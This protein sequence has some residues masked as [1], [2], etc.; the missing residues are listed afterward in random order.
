MYVKIGPYPKHVSSYE[1][2]RKLERHIGEDRADKISDFVAPLFH[3]W[4]AR[5]WNKR[6]IKVKIH[7]SDVWS[8]DSTLAFIILPALK[9][10]KDTKH[11][12]PFVDDE[13]VPDNLKS[14]FAPPI[15]KEN[16][17]VDD[18]HYA[19]WDY[20]LDQMIWSFE[21]VNSDWEDEFHKDGFDYVGYQAHYKKMEDGM[22]LF[23]K[24]YFHL[25]D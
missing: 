4:N 22:K 12:S 18:N 21:Q 24:Y 14:T 9:K 16:G 25:W 2:F 5:P 8:L 10:L 1:L 20:I 23:G 11:G 17:E 7:P 6:K 3:A 13:D 19:R 15:K